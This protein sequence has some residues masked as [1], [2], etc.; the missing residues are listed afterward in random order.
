M[1]DYAR[2]LANALFHKKII[3]FA[4][5]ELLPNAQLQRIVRILQ[6]LALVLI[7]AKSKEIMIVHAEKI[8]YIALQLKLAQVMRQI[9]ESA[10]ILHPALPMVQICVF[11]EKSLRTLAT[12]ILFAKI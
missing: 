4:E 11:A 5:L 9:L 6:L 8:I 2:L 1:P 12:Q 7:H 10:L 3:A